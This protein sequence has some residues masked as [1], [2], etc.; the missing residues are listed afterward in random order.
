MY[1]ISVIALLWLAAMAHGQ[2]GDSSQPSSHTS[3]SDEAASVK[4]Q[5]EAF[6]EAERTYD[7]TAA[8]AILADEF[9]LTGNHGEQLNK[10]A[11]VALIGDKADPLEI[12][13]YGDLEVR[14]YGDAAVVWSTIRE[15]ALYNGKPDEYFGR[16]TAMW[17]K[18]GIRWQCVTIHT[19]AFENNKA[20][21]HGGG[22]SA[23][24]AAAPTTLRQTGDA[25]S[26][27]VG[28]AAASA[29]L[30]EADYT[31]I[32]G[33]EFSQLQAE[34]EMKFGLI[35]PRP[36]TDPH[37]YDFTG[38]DAL[39]SFAEAHNM[40]VRGHTLVW[41]NQVSKW[42]TEGK[43][44]SSQLG[45]I[46][47]SHINNVVTHYAS[48]V[49]AWDVVNEAFNDNGSMRS[50][51]WYDHP[52]IGV[53]KGTK[54]IEQA[55]RWARAADPNAKLFYNDYDAEEMNSKSDAIYDMA[56]DFKKRGVPLDGI[57]FQTHISL[58]FDDRKKLESF[59]DNMER[60][61]KLGLELH[62][63]ELDVRLNDS[64]PALLAW[65][66]K[67][68]GEITT[69]C[70]QQPA[71]KLLQTWGFTDKHSWIPGFYKGQGWAL[72]WDDKYQKKPAYE[73]VRDALA[74]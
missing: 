36:D 10:T 17:V 60:F 44:S 49:Y 35:H 47:H 68:Y 71:C 21:V 74:H 28:A 14:A 64:S 61:A 65:E 69:L 1:K 46:L 51:I 24:P 15:R 19:S 13:D 5:E 50:T 25:H 70:V 57:G 26:I 38:G 8:T 4:A 40:K 58:K 27:V 66:A 31:T 2:T 33:S 23:Q 6:R 30:S 67:L 55:F 20:P 53:G 72:L 43:F 37:P 29:Y 39:V 63:T 48:K 73:A 7:T 16:R 45:E 41:H 12:P 22:A 59:A 56:K 11:F 42:V 3:Q 62:I 32:L 54:Y 34:N 18:R 52:G 9:L